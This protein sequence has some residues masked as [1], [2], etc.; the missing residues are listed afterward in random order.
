M[1]LWLGFVYILLPSKSIT[2]KNHYVVRLLDVQCTEIYGEYTSEDMEENIFKLWS[3]T[4]KNYSYGL[5]KRTNEFL[6]EV[7]ESYVTVHYG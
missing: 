1:Y 3:K 4:K 2:R 6:T 5:I 7:L